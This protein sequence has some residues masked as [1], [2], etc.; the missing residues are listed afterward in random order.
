MSVCLPECVCVCVCECVCGQAKLKRLVPGPVI[1][2]IYQIQI[3]TLILL[4]IFILIH[5]YIHIFIQPYTHSGCYYSI[6]IARCRVN[7]TMSVHE[8]GVVGGSEDVL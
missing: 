4:L 8:T 6:A 5:S 2:R 7:D 1:K 3:L